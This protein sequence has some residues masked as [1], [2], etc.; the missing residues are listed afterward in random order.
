MTPGA[1]AAAAIAA[2][3]RVAGGEAAEKALTG[4]ARGARYAGSK[5]RAAVRDHVFDVL[6]RWRSTAAMGGGETG[7]ARMIG[8]LRQEGI[9]PEA[10]F[11]G[12]GHAPA[13]LTPAEASAVEIPSGPVALDMPDWL[14]TRFEADLGVDATTVAETQ[15]HRAPVFLRANVLKTTP[16]AAIAALA[17]DGIVAV[18]A[19]RASAAL[20]VTDGARRIAGSCAYR[21]GLVELQD[22]SSQAIVD[23]LPLA[24]GLRVLDFCAGGGGKALAMAARIGGPV[25][26]WDAARQRLRDL[27]T[28]AARA[29]AEITILDAPRGRFDLVLC[30][31]PC[32]GSGT[33]RRAPEGKWRLDQAALDRLLRTQ[34]QILRDAARH[35]A[36]G[37]TLAYATCSVLAAENDT[38]V[39]ALLSEDPRWRAAETVRYLP[40]DDGDG[41]FLKL[42]HI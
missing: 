9:A 42:L 32:S 18:R 24:T 13:P 34:S 10:L 31:V 6:R 20:R 25:S 28:R 33:W 37:G 22:A 3:D 39:A 27:P 30:D 1:R 4:W 8:L 11:T 17:E 29:G 2:L 7:R 35:V 21:N 23:A 15:R 16:E 12:E 40:D 26:A 14:W 36:P 19:E 41:L 5:D 38:A